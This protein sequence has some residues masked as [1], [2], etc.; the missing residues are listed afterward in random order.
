MNDKKQVLLAYINQLKKH[1]ILLQPVANLILIPVSHK[2]YSIC[3]KSMTIKKINGV[4][5]TLYTIDFKIVWLS[6]IN[7]L[8]TQSKKKKLRK[9]VNK[10]K[11]KFIRGK[12]NKSYRS[13][14]HYAF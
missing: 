12:Y 4:G 11:K 3:Y 13:H 5:I 9:I 1:D 14:R 8:N 2:T 6:E 10:S 7:K